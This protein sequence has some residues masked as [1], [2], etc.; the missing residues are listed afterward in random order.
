[1]KIKISFWFLTFAFAA[2][3]LAPASAPASYISV[4]SNFSQKATLNTYTP[5]I[6]V[7]A[8]ATVNANWFKDPS[9]GQMVLAFRVKWTGANGGAGA[10]FKLPLPTGYTFDQSRYSGTFDGAGNTSQKFTTTGEFY[11]QG[12]NIEGPVAAAF[13]ASTLSV[14]LLYVGLM[15]DSRPGTDDLLDITVRVWVNGPG[16]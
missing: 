15:T 6:P 5:A 2:L 11:N 10:A 14:E 13:D 16:F 7:L 12:V 9:S 3:A 4:G 8:N 1:M